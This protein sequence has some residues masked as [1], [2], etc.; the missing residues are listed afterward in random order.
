MS[1][2]IDA[3]ALIEKL[4]QHHDFF[5]KAWGGFKEMPLSD[6]A[7]CDEL[8]NCIAEIVNAPSIDIVWCKECIKHNTHR[9][10]MA[11]DLIATEDD[12]FCSYGCREEE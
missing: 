10:H 5:V 7:R 2:W 6:K 11:F 9:C 3:D 4:K 1:R 12:D 8:T